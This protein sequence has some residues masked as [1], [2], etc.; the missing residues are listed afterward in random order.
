MLTGLVTV[1]IRHGALVGRLIDEDLASREL[2]VFLSC[3]VIG[4]AHNV[5]KLTY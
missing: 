5:R 3:S 1:L 4:T 2:W